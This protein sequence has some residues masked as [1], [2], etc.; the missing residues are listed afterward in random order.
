M[1]QLFNFFTVLSFCKHKSFR[2]INHKSSLLKV[3]KTIRPSPWERQMAKAWGIRIN[4]YCNST[5][6]FINENC[7]F[8]TFF[9][10]LPHHPPSFAPLFSF[11]LILFLFQSVPS[12]SLF[13]AL[14]YF[15]RQT[16]ATGDTA[17]L[18]TPK[19]TVHLAH[20]VARQQHTGRGPSEINGG[21][22][23]GTNKLRIKGSSDLD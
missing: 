19:S 22:E 21:W 5:H 12:P 18:I 16:L 4:V 9:F 10:F 17:L 6:Y 1:I 7:T 13:P 20:R 14:L 2:G 15:H 3:Q 11:P 23:N 8:C